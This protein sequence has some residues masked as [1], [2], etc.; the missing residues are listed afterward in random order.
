MEWKLD[1]TRLSLMVREEKREGERKH[2][3]PID[4]KFGNR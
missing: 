3:G 2:K 1:I 4:G